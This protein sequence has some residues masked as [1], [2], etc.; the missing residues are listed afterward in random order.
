[1]T[2]FDVIDWYSNFYECRMLL[3]GKEYG[4]HPICQFFVVVICH[5]VSDVLSLLNFAE[6]FGIVYS[7]FCPLR[8]I[9]VHGFMLNDDSRTVCRQY[10]VHKVYKS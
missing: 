7:R 1:M 5:M 10:V 3:Y 2:L 8:V 4:I 6:V 9:P